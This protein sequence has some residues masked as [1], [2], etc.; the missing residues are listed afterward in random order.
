MVTF[1]PEPLRAKI[2]QNWNIVYDMVEQCPK[3]F[4]LHVALISGGAVKKVTWD[5][6]TLEGACAAL[7]E[8]GVRA[9]RIASP[10]PVPDDLTE[11][12]L[13]FDPA[14]AMLQPE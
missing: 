9:V 12:Y 7:A 10:L 4:R 5:S 1:D 14:S 11:I 8:A 6:E 13:D 3:P 2:A